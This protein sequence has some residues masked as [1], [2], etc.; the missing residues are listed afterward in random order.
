MSGTIK[1]GV[2]GILTDITGRVLLAKRSADDK[3]LPGMWCT[4]GGGVEFCEGLDYALRREFNEEVGLHVE[5]LDTVAVEESV[6]EV[7]SEVR[8]AVMVFKRVRLHD[9]RNFR[10]H[11]DKTELSDWAWFWRAQLFDLRGEIT[12]MTYAALEKFYANH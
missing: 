2:S 7:A 8:H 10:V 3:S 11:L 5:V 4:P 1:V 6:R 12:N 9:P